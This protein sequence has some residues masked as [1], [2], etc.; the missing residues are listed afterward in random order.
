LV[1]QAHRPPGMGRV[2]TTSEIEPART[3]DVH[4][5]DKGASAP[6]RGVGRGER[7]GVMRREGVASRQTSSVVVKKMWSNG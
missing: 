1:R 7:G 3:S 5:D 6:R 2:V 4:S